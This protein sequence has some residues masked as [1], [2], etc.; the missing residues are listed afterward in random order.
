MVS[1]LAS[2]ENPAYP[3]SKEAAENRHVFKQKN[4]FPPV[5]SLAFAFFFI[6]NSYSKMEL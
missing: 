5:I 3:Q 2:P 4:V 6:Y 1:I